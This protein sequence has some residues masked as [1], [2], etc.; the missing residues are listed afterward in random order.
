MSKEEDLLRRRIASLEGALKVI[1]TWA[2]APGALVPHNVREV[3]KARMPF[4]TWNEVATDAA[5]KTPVTDGPLDLRRELSISAKSKA[6]K[7][8]AERRVG[9]L[10]K[11]S[12]VRVTVHKGCVYISVDGYNVFA[13]EADSVHVDATSKASP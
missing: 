13:V 3:I 5:P 2:G 6:L 1:F 9:V 8:L 10:T 11:D 7:Q 12:S 4:S